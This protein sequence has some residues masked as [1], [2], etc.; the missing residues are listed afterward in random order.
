MTLVPQPPPPDGT[1]LG[2]LEMLGDPGAKGFS[3]G[4][5]PGAFE[6]F[7]V[8]RGELL[9]GYI[10]DCPHAHT[11]LEFMPDR[12][13]TMDGGAIICATH[14]A[15]FDLATGLCFL[16]PC[17]GRGLTRFPVHAADGKLIVGRAGS[18]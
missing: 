13:L 4:S 10:N 2:P 8:R 3:F 5:G 6:F 9:R 12:F 7:V 14:G 16:G 15:Q 17:R 11:P 18:A 1:V